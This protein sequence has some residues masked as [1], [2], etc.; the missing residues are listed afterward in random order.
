MKQS[1]CLALAC[2]MAWPALAQ[3]PAP[4]AAAEPQGFWVRPNMLGDIGG[5][6]TILGRAG[7]TVTLTEQ[8]EVL[9][10]LSGGLKRGATYD[11]LTT[12]TL[13]LDTQKAFGWNG[14]TFNVSALQIH[15]RNL[16]QFYLANLHT[17]SGIEATPTTRLWE[18]WYQQA[19]LDGKLDVKIGQQSVDQ[20]FINSGFSALF[21][22]TMMGWP[23]LPSADLYAGGPAYPFSSLGVRLRAQPAEGFTVLAGVFQDN[24]PGGPFNND[25]QLRGNTR[26]GGNLNLRTGAL[27][28]AELQYV[29]NQRAAYKLGAWYDT[30][31]FPDQRFDT[32]GGLLADPAGT[33]TP[34][35]RRGNISVYALADQ[36]IWRPNPDSPRALAIFARVMGAPGDRNLVDVSVNAGITLKAPLPGR[37]DD[38][39]GI[40]YGLANISRN[41]RG[42]DRDGN[43]F[44]GTALPVR[45]HEQF[46]E[47]TYQAQITPWLQVQ[48]D[49]QYVIRP[50]GGVADPNVPGRRL[51]DEVIV[52]VRANITF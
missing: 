25:G 14:G 3:T 30:A 33:G 7:I 31:H 18:V 44:G 12:L 21:V 4:D 32:A 50:A 38:T 49:F 17:V 41:A 9:A 48:P 45:G 22:N 26:W 28:M 10:N 29:I 2:L 19:F 27:F 16:S 40:G 42:F 37:D 34:R 43:V 13:Q 52:G 6:R 15:G 11:G 35:M 1:A 46:I 8:S 47:V 23:M 36:T 51:G 20:E 5:M 39:F 24:P